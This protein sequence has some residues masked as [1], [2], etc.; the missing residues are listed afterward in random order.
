MW[1]FLGSE[2]LLFAGLFGLYAGYRSQYPQAFALGVAHD[3]EW[4]GSTNTFIL[5]IS[6]FF[7]AWAVHCLRLARL[8]LTVL[9]LGLALALGG[10]FLCLKAIE[11]S[12]H[13][14]HGLAPGHYYSS[15]ELVQPGCNIFFTLYYFMTG[16]HAIH[17]IAGMTLLAWLALRVLRGRTTPTR[18]VELEL[19]GLYW[20]LVDIIWI[21]L[22][23]MLY[24]IK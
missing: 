1:V 11:Y 24:L 9:S 3:A 12:D 8:R 22:W 4:I 17:V 20:H 10:A 16:L 19:G 2:T 7:V 6:S 5:L 15:R 21:F 23:P 13:L 18:H 14:S